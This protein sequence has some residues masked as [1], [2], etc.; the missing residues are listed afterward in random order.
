MVTGELGD[1]VDRV[2]LG[3]GIQQMIVALGDAGRLDTETLHKVFEIVLGDGV[4]WDGVMQDLKRL[5]GSV[6]QLANKVSTLETKVNT[7]QTEMHNR[8]ETSNEILW[9]LRITLGLVVAIV[10]VYIWQVW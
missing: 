7:L 1:N 4:Q 8:R 9:T 10:A 2:A 5:R 3:K 6:E